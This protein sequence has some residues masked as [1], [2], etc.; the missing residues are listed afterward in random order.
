MLIGTPVG[1]VLVVDDEAMVRRMAVLALEGAG[2]RVLTAADAAEA[3]DLCRD[4]EGPIDVVVMDVIL[5][6]AHGFDVVPALRAIRANL[7]VVYMSG[8]PGQM[9]FERLNI[10][11][12]FLSKPFTPEELV[13]A[14][15]DAAGHENRQRF[16]PGDPRRQ[17]HAA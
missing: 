9:L 6:N 1:T 3:A 16:P 17:P 15:A 10:G 14:V 12:P 4:H 8:Y 5:E 2:Y 7:K 11:D 13:G